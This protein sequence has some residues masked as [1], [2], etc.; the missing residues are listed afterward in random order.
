MVVILEVR[1]FL[2]QEMSLSGDSVRLH[3]VLTVFPSMERAAVFA[4][5]RLRSRGGRP[6]CCSLALSFGSPII[7]S[8]ASPRRQVSDVILQFF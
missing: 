5:W 1:V 3:R 7:L 6:L 8:E 4:P 2:F